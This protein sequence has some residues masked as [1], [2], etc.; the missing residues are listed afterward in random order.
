MGSLRQFLGLDA[1]SSSK[2]LSR[3]AFQRLLDLGS[4]S[5]SAI[6]EN[7]KDDEDGACSEDRFMFS[8]IDEDDEDD[9][10]SNLT[11]STATSSY[12]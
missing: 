1:L 12:D 8:A 3:K 11:A 9:A 10:R 7:G 6:D 5:F 2:T 4:I